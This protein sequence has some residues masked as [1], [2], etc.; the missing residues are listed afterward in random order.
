MKLHLKRGILFLGFLLAAFA[1][2]AGGYA[3]GSNRYGQPK[4]II[5]LVVV[6]WKP[7][8]TDAQKQQV[9]DGIKKMAAETPGIEN[10]WV[11]PARVQP[12]DFSTAFVI[13]FKDRAAADAYAESAAHKAFDDMYV[14]LRADS[15]SIQVTN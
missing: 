11:K 15:L 13:E 1:V 12:R 7:G 10:I 4:T 6:K 14:P 8:V 3:L 9:L 5:H 2:A